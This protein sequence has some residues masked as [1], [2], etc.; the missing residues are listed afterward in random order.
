[1]VL[2]G[3]GLRRC[4]RVCGHSGV[5][6]ASEPGSSHAFVQ[7]LDGATG[8]STYHR[9]PF[10]A[11]QAAPRA[12]N[13]QVGPNRFRLDRMALD[14]QSPDRTARGELAFAGGT[15]WPVTFASPGIMGWYA[16]VP[17]MECY[18]GC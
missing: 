1:V 11:F 2:Q 17:F 9:Y 16:H 4:A 5:F 6:I 10:D 7:I 12:F 3:G 15:G 14:I 13:I 18:H 8:F